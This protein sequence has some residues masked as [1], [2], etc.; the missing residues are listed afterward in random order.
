MSV[1]SP[2]LPALKDPVCGMTVTEQS[3][4]VF[5]YIGKPV[6]FCSAGCKTKFAADPAKY[7]VADSSSD[8][9]ALESSPASTDPIPRRY[10]IHMPNAP[11]GSARSRG[12]LP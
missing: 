1:D 8:S 5:N 6:Y 4:N 11:R 10:D 3:P 12:Y 9:K 7:L 2:V